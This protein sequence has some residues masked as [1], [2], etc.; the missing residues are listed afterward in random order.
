MLGLEKGDR[1]WPNGQLPP[2]GGCS[3]MKLLVATRSPP[4]SS[5]RHS[6]VSV[7]IGGRI[8]VDGPEERCTIGLWRG[9]VSALFYVRPVERDVA[10]L[11]S[12]TFRT[13]RMPW[14]KRVPPHDDAAAQESLHAL[15]ELLAAQGWEKMRPGVGANWYAFQFRRKGNAA[16]ARARSSAARSSNVPARDRPAQPGTKKNRSALATPKAS[17]TSSYNG[18][19][20]LGAPSRPASEAVRPLRARRRRAPRG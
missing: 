17:T 19:R 11:L 4:P 8:Q 3:I 6:D 16:A 5:L 2:A 20:A 7:P 14:K 15:E 12:P 13:W 10:M 9:Y 18:A 1:P